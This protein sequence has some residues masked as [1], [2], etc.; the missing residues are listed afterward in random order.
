MTIEKIGVHNVKS[1]QLLLV[2]EVYEYVYHVHKLRVKQ[3]K[4]W[5]EDFR[6][7]TEKCFRKC[8]EIRSVL[9]K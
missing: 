7:I 8:T 2:I 5:I 4:I 9:P 3:S 1:E 6:M